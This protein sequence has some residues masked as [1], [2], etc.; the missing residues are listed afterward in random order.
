MIM[1]SLIF[2]G[3]V[4]LA[5]G[6]VLMVLAGF[7]HNFSKRHFPVEW[8]LPMGPVGIVVWMIYEHREKAAIKKAVAAAARKLKKSQK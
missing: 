3:L 5:I 4:W 6:A 7:T 2:S 8:M 1:A